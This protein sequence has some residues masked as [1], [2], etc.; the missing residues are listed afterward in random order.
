MTQA[1]TALVLNADFAP[2]SRFPLSIWPFEHTMKKV[3]KDRVSV[4]A[5][6]GVV[7]RS[8]SLAYEVP[9]VV[10]L[11]DYVR[12]P[13][14]VPFTRLNLLIRDQFRCQYC[15]EE[16]ASKDLTFDHVVP[17]SKGGPSTW[18]NAVTACVP[19]NQRKGCRQDMK[20]L[21]APYEPTVYEMARLR[22][23]D[24]RN[25]HASQLDFLYWSGALQR[26]E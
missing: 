8:P 25:F 16:F 13:E 3:L 26:D 15:G 20:P 24:T 21:R 4:L 10:M 2:V 5:T 11:K 17:R 7:L 9:S 22:M 12:R 19:C 18:T 14:R 6:Y 1:W 23:P